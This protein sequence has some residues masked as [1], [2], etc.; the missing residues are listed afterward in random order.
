MPQLVAMGKSKSNS[1]NA[2]KKRKALQ[3]YQKGRLADAEAAYRALCESSPTDPTAPHMLGLVYGQMRRLNEAEAQ[4][5]RALRLQPSS[6]DTHY[7]LGGTRVFLGKLTAAAESFSEAIRLAPNM[8]EAHMELG[9]VLLALE[10]LREAKVA[11]QGAVRV[12]PTLALAHYQ[13]GRIHES[14][15]ESEEAMVRYGSAIEHDP[16]LPLA[17]CQL[18]GLLIAKGRTAEAREHFR[19][20]QRLQPDLVTAI[21]GEAEACARSGD[22]QGAYSLLAPLLDQNE[23]HPTVGLV[24]ARISGRGEQA[25]EYLEGVLAKTDLSTTQKAKCHMALGRLYDKAHR[26]DEAFAHLRQGNQVRSKFLGG[27]NEAHEVLMLDR[28]VETFTMEAMARLPR[29]RATEQRMIF[30]VGMPRSGTSL[31]EQVL[32]SHP[33]VYGAGELPGINDL[34]NIVPSLTGNRSPYPMAAHHLT[35]EALDSLAQMYLDTVDGPAGDAIRITDKMPHNFGHLGLINL[36]FPQ[37]RVI[38]C[39]RNP[40]DNCLSIYTREF[41]G[42]HP[43]GSDLGALGRYYRMYERLMRHWKNVVEL[44]ILDVHY[45]DTVS[46]LERQTRRLLEFCGLEWDDRCLRFYENKREIDTASYDQVRQPLYT[47]AV[48]RW[49]HYERHLDELQRALTQS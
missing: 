19:A 27:Y 12:K 28:L 37:A 3:L 38:H 46:D 45:E 4:F 17:H 24:Y 11:Y 1:A 5:E 49:R 16:K 30:I 47:H 32:A 31:T 13:L 10:R 2:L 7:L 44:P 23:L 22:H 42:F 20:A 8:A 21:T 9:N 34:A 48:G 33:Q 43:Y 39:I 6:S 41:I 25:A 26:Y 18:G 36:L 14:L 40:M 29:G 35:A 15:G